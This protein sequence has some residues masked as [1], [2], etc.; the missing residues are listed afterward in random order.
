MVKRE[1]KAKRKKMVKRKKWQNGKKL[2]KRKKRQKGKKGQND[3]FKKSV[4]K[5][6][7]AKWHCDKKAKRQKGGIGGRQKGERI[8]DVKRGNSE[9]GKKE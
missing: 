5:G 1:N 7:K 2:A 9:S 8:V 3:F 6:E 4:S